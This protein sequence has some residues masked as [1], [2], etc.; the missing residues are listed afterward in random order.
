MARSEEM[1]FQDL[2]RDEIFAKDPDVMA[3]KPGHPP[4]GTPD[5]IVFIKGGGVC[6]L[7]AKAYNGNPTPKQK[8]MIEKYRKLGIR[9]EVVRTEKKVRKIIQEVKA[10][11]ERRQSETSGE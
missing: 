3:Y 7:E 11:A 2:M 5:F 1:R 6:V 10:N 9:A 4:K 8:D